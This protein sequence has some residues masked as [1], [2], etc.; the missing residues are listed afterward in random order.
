[1][2]NVRAEEPGITTEPQISPSAESSASLLRDFAASRENM[3]VA[4]LRLALD[5]VAEH[6]EIGTGYGIA[7]DGNLP[8]VLLTQKI[9]VWRWQ[10][11]RSEIGLGLV[12]ATLFTFSDND[13]DLE[14]I[15]VG[16]SWHWFKSPPWVADVQS[17]PV[18]RTLL[19][20]KF[21]E[22]KLS[23]FLGLPAED[24]IKGQ[25]DRRRTIAGIGVSF[26]F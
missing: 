16:A 18:I 23:P 25:F 5:Y 24:L 3:F 11:R 4:S 14:L 13:S 1:V 6:G 15:G 9:D 17:L 21:T 12:H 2:V 19:F 10:V 26:R 8:G 20:V 22:F 7:L